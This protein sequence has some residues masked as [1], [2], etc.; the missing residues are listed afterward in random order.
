VF[1]VTS[2]TTTAIDEPPIVMLLGLAPTI[3][4]PS[5]VVPSAPA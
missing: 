3:L 2:P 1:A 4:K 5:T